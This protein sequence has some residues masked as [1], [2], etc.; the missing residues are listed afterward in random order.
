MGPKG[1]HWAPGGP[2]GAHGAPWGP[3]V[4][5]R[6]VSDHLGIPRRAPNTLFL[7]IPLGL[8]TKA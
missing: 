7:K 8:P 2:V 3:T 1:P 4:L 6:T 5:R